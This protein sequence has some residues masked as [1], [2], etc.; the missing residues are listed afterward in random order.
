[1]S[2][3]C[4]WSIFAAIGSLLWLFLALVAS[5]GELAGFWFLGETL[6]FAPLIIIPLG[7]SLISQSDRQGKHP[8][9]WNMAVLFHWPGAL[10]S[11][12][13]LYTDAPT[14]KVMGATL[15]CAQT[16]IIGVFGLWRWFWSGFVALEENVIN[17]GCLYLSVGG[18]WLL[19]H[20]A[21]WSLGFDNFIVL[22]TAMHFHYAGFA[23]PVIA[24]LVGRLVPASARTARR[25][26]AMAALFIGLAPPLVG[27][28]ISGSPAVEMASAIA[29]ATGVLLLSGIILLRIVMGIEHG[30]G[31]LLLMLSAMGALFPMLY[32]V[33][34]ALGE[35]SGQQ[36]LD[37]KTMVAWHGWANAYVFVG[38]GMLGFAMI[39]PS[40]RINGPWPPLSRLRAPSVVGA[41]FFKKHALVREKQSPASGLVVAMEEYR[42]ADFDPDKVAPAIRHF[43]EHTREWTLH[44]RASWG[45]PYASMASLYRIWAR[46]VGQMVLPMG[47]LAEGDM[48]SSIG[49]LDDAADGRC[50]VRYWVRTCSTSGDP[51]YVAAYSTHVTNAV[52]YMNIAFPLPGGNMTSILRFDHDP[53]AAGAVVLSTHTSDGSC[54]DEGIYFVHRRTPVRLPIQEAIRVWPS[55]EA[56]PD[57]PADLRPRSPFSCCA[58][59]DVWLCGFR[60]LTLWYRLERRA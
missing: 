29:L 43:Y 24:G 31:R 48:A 14:L 9:I 4:P 18:F 15:W 45:Q 12:V 34:Y 20:S 50:H 23:S 58:R 60:C 2:R 35:L 59:H 17:L 52:A 26:Y 33:R 21:N 55:A 6:L 54:G 49:D 1:M 10:G 51:I 11:I 42:R 25:L 27:I 28:G 32:A 56:P 13:A 47:D 40:A 38:A 3:R 44:V 5:P 39:R 22:L 16:V 36:V 57:F 37:L 7:L 30:V 46:R 19:A 8:W 53:S 41:D